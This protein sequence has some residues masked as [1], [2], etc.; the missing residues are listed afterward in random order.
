MTFH[1]YNYD[2][3]ICIRMSIPLHILKYNEIFKSMKK[4][5]ETNKTTTV[6]VTLDA[7]TFLEDILG[8]IDETFQEIDKQPEQTTEGFLEYYANTDTTFFNSSPN[9][10]SHLYRPSTCRESVEAASVYFSNFDNNFDVIFFLLNLCINIIKFLIHCEKTTDKS[11]FPVTSIPKKSPIYTDIFCVISDYMSMITEGLKESQ[12]MCFLKME[13]TQYMLRNITRKLK[14]YT[15]KD[16]M[17]TWSDPQLL[18][19]YTSSWNTKRLKRYIKKFNFLFENMHD[20]LL[21][22]ACVQPYL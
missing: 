16:E 1:V 21:E 20:L 6:G 17:F 3:H 15:V 12:Q 19:K 5:L 14:T 9:E 7:Y 4:N 10:Y 11:E 2:Q 22:L 13:D 8:E 18:E